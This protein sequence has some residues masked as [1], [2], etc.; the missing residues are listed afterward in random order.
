M[1]NHAIPADLLPLE[2]SSV[3]AVAPGVDVSPFQTG[4][5]TSRRWQNLILRTYNWTL[6]LFKASGDYLEQWERF[7]YLVGIN[8]NPVWIIEPVSGRHN[9]VQC[10]GLADGSQTTFPLPAQSA[11]E[12]SA[13]VA[14]VLQASSVYTVHA[15]ANLLSDYVATGYLPSIGDKWAETACTTLQN[16][17]TIF[18]HGY[19]SDSV[20]PDA[21]STCSIK[22]ADTVAATA[23]KE[24][25]ASVAFRGPHTVKVFIEWYNDSPALISTSTSTGTAGSESA[26]QQ[27]TL[28]ATAPAFTDTVKIGVEITS[29]ADTD[30]MYLDCFSF[31]PGDLTD[32][33][34]P[35]Q[36]PAV[37]E[38]DSAP[39]AK[40]RVKAHVTGYRMARCRLSTSTLSWSLSS[41][42]HAAPQRWTAKE[43]VWI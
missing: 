13:F 18:A 36:S 34:L 37:I 5:T 10:G 21:A 26:W 12:T 19:T 15:A 16:I 6:S 9:G 25:T 28:T 2:G 11:T 43:E 42:G 20:I 23:A 39:S 32:W 4:P 33:F 40:A 17:E 29:P 1:I 7:L 27:E 8:A 31:G 38:L 35:S 3:G 14:D 41:Q 24:Y 22:A 30:P